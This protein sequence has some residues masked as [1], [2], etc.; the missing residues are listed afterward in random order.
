MAGKAISQQIPQFRHRVFSNFYYNPAYACDPHKPEFSLN[1]RSQWVGFEG[2]PTTSSLAGSYMFR[3]DMAGGLIV[4]SDKTGATSRTL[5]SLNYAYNLKINHDWNLSFGLAWTIM[6]SKIDGSNIS[7]HD[8][9]DEIVIEN[10]TGKVWKPDANVG[11]MVYNGKFY[12]GISAMQVFE[13]KYQLYK[14]S[15]EGIDAERHYFIN[16][17]A[18]IPLGRKQSSTFHPDILME[19]AYGTPFSFDI[20]GIWEYNNSLLAGLTYSLSDAISLNLGYKYQDI[21]FMYS[22]DI[23]INYLMTAASGAHEL[24]LSY[25]LKGKGEKYA[26]PMF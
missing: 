6:Q 14:S 12:A 10:L 22:Y 9:S 25:D 4:S 20:S 23:V 15:S 8:N 5:F 18:H 16:T 19:F 2:S 24:T 1:H 3:N 7:L 11:I 17:G 13:T 21:T 26:Q